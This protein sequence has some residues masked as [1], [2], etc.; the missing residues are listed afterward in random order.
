MLSALFSW[1]GV[2]RRAISW[3]LP[4][5]APRR[6]LVLDSRF[7]RPLR[8]LGHTV[9]APG[10]K[11]ELVCARAPLEQPDAAL[12]ELVRGYAG[13]LS[14]GGLVIVRSPAGERE[15]VAAAFLHAGLRD[16]EQARIGRGFLTSGVV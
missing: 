6:A 14:D 12:I 4:D 15:R 3:L 10:E 7:L 16:V 11:V 8:A 2:S 5:G 13:S 9:V 1:P